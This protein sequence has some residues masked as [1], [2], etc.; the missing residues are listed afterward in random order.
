LGIL[1]AGIRDQIPMHRLME[2][3]YNAMAERTKR[4]GAGKPTNLPLGS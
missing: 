1:R 3:Q 2:I 4:L